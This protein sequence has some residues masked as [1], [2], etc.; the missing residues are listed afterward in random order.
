MRLSAARRMWDTAPLWKALRSSAAI[1]FH[2]KGVHSA[3]LRSR[4]IIPPFPSA[5]MSTLHAQVYSFRKFPSAKKKKKSSHFLQLKHCQK[6]TIHLASPRHLLRA[7]RLPLVRIHLS[8]WQ[9]W[10]DLLAIFVLWERKRLLLRYILYNTGFTHCFL[11]PSRDL[12]KK[13]LVIDRARRLGNMKV[14]WYDF[15]ALYISYVHWVVWSQQCEK[16]DRIRKGPQ[17]G[18]SSTC[19]QLV[20][21][22]EKL[23]SWYGVWSRMDIYLRIPLFV[24]GLTCIS[25]YNSPVYCNSLNSLS[26]VIL[27]KVIHDSVIK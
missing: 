17:C 19:F 6:D 27:W 11:S 9:R 24:I 7:V 5:P 20:T 1:A 2:Q 4:W 14:S 12:I 25:T 3:V 22:E 18:W 10:K 16:Q 23:Q 13:F 21:N 26:N 8:F 15:L